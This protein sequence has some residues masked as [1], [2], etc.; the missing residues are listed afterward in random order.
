MKLIILAAPGAGKGTQAEL[1]SKHFNI[2]T[3]S[4]G[5]ILRKNISE[6]TELGEIAGK[7]INDGK[8]IPDDVMIK[9]VE[10]RLL[11]SD[12]ENGFILDGF[13]RTIAQAEALEN[14][15]IKIDA[16]LTIEVPDEKI[17]ERL[18]GRLEC[19]NCGST[20]HKLYRAPKTEG[21]CDNCGGKLETRADDKPETVKERLA[22]YHEQTEPLKKFYADRNMLRV[23]HGREEIADTTAE[24]IKA[25]QQ[26]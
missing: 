2:P 1:L 7:Y 22:T 26:C 24:V 19:K 8:L 18:G 21:V 3:I 25:L 23:A 15:H 16:V 10:E 12:C 11:E 13:P 14:S 9:V 6:G 5:A 4:T 17:I 20:Y